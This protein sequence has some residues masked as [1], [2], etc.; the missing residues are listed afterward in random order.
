MMVVSPCY[1]RVNLFKRRISVYLRYADDL[2]SVWIYVSEVN[3]SWL[4][5]K[6]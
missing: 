2:K 3:E 1:T 6:L 4:E 5:I